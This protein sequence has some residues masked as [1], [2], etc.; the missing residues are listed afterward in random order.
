MFLLV[1]R[2]LTECAADSPRVVVVADRVDL[3]EQ[4]KDTFRRVGADVAQGESS[5]ELEKLLRSHRSRVIKTTIHNFGTFAKKGLQPIDDAN[6][7]VLV[8]E[9]HRTQIGTLHASMRR[10]LP[11]A[12]LC[13]FAGT[14]ILRG[15]KQTPLAFGGIIDTYTIKDSRGNRGLQAVCGEGGG[16]ASGA[17]SM[18]GELGAFAESFNGKFRE[19]TEADGH[20]L[21][22]ARKMIREKHSHTGARRHGAPSELLDVVELE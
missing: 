15:D 9:G 20:G 17:S 18:C 21:L 16:T 1:T 13:G 14:P 7:F 5:G 22:N 4:I 2:L 12:S 10:A 8:D 11:K 19:E 3:D 6:V